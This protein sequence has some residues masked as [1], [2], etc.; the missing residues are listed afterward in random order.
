MPVKNEKKSEHVHLVNVP[1]AF[2]VKTWSERYVE[3]SERTL[4]EDV[5]SGKIAVVECG[6]RRLITAEAMTAYLKNHTRPG[7][8]AEAEARRILEPGGACG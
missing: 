8:D 1:C 3:L 4:W 7:F 5:K 2:S 6:R